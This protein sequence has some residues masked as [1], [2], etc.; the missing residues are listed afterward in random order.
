[1]KTPGQISV[2]NEAQITS[3]QKFK[4]IYNSKHIHIYYYMCSM[5]ITEKVLN[6]NKLKGH[7]RFQ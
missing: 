6:F 5:G 3:H 4:Y 7:L 2:K 1:M